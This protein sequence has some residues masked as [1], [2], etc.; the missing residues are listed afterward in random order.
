M[1]KLDTPGM[2]LPAHAGIPLAGR[3]FR[4]SQLDTTPIPHRSETKEYV[5]VQSIKF[6]RENLARLLAISAA[7]LL[8]CFWHRT[9]VAGDLGSHMYNAWLAQ[10]VE[11]GEAPGLWL[12]ERWNNVLFDLLLDG[13]GRFFSWNVTEKIAVSLAVLIFF[14]GTVALVAAATRRMPWFVFPCIAM[15]AYG[16]SFHMGFLNFYISMGLA[17]FGIAIFWRGKR[18]ERLIPVALAPLIMLAHPL[19]FAWLVAGSAY[20]TIAEAIPRRYQIFLLLAGAAFLYAARYYFW[21]HDIVQAQD[22]PLYFFNGTDQLLL[23]GSRYAIPEYALLGFIVVALAAD[24]WSRGWRQIRWTDYAVSLQ[25]YVIACLAVILLP[26]GIRFPHQPSSLALVTERFTS[27]SAALLCCLLGAMKPHKWH[28]IGFSMI[29]AVFFAFLYQ[30]TA[31]I[32]AM[33]AQVERLVRTLPPDRRVLATIKPFPGS[34]IL[35]QHMVDRACIGYCFSYGNY[36]PGSA[37]FRVRVTPESRIVMPEFDPTS[38]MEDGT[39]EVQP[40]DLPA[41]Q[42][43]QCSVNG[44]DLCIRALEAG[45]MNDRLGVHADE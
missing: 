5:I 38:D 42:V 13:L 26:D 27:I 41:Y 35:I 45:E 32:N 21:H 2:Q 7:V 10:L 20:V 40:E 4:D 31:T 43:Y 34:R 30:D 23:F 16:Y 8:P 1:K 22:G 11:H 17:F 39:Y 3:D 24:L 18:W 29:A 36:E 14:W 6:A 12:V 9:I 25:L 15:F 28:L 44:K 37:Q 33:E 19:G